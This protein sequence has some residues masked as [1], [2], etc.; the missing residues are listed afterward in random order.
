MRSS[1]DA[2]RRRWR[3]RKRDERLRWCCCGGLAPLVLLV[4]SWS[5]AQFSE[6]A[7]GGAERKGSSWCS[8]VAVVEEVE[9]WLLWG[10]RSRRLGGG[11]Q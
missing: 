9:P 7:R 4:L 3:S 10:R 1:T 6:A 5:A 8:A 2:C 11:C